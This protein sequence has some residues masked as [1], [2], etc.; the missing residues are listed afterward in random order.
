LQHIY[1]Y[2]TLIEGARIVETYGTPL[3]VSALYFL[4]L[5]SQ[6]LPSRILAS[7]HGLLF[8]V[9]IEFTTRF[10]GLGLA[11]QWRR[12]IFYLLMATGLASVVFSVVY[13]M[14]GRKA[15]PIIHFAQVL[16]LSHAL[17]FE[18]VTEL[19]FGPN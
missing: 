3:A 19:S 5:A 6:P 9:A 18:Y 13:S 4:V 12:G 17:T 11:M 15:K 2:S 1:W 16:N 10:G 8:I 7:A 14:W